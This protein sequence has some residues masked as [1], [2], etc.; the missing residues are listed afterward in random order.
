MGVSPEAGADVDHRPRHAP[1]HPVAQALPAASRHIALGRAVDEV[2]RAPRAAGHRVMTAIVPV[3]AAPPC[4]PPPRS[5]SSAVATAFSSISR[6]ARPGVREA[7]RTGRAACRGRRARSRGRRGRF[8]AVRR[9][10]RGPRHPSLSN[11]LG[12]DCARAAHAQVLRARRRAA[13]PARR[14]VEA[15]ARARPQARSASA[16]A[17]VAPTTR[18]LTR[19]PSLRGGVAGAVGTSRCGTDAWAA[20]GTGRIRTGRKRTR[21]LVRRRIVDLEPEAG[22]E[23]PLGREHARRRSLPQLA[24][25]TG[26]WA[27]RRR[28]HRQDVPGS[29]AST[30]VQPR[31]WIRLPRGAPRR[32]PPIDAAFTRRLGERAEDTK[33][34]TVT[35]GGV[36]TP[37]PLGHAEHVLHVLRVPG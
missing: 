8:G 7:S 29:L 11:A 34:C 13:T 28:E 15:R 37:R 10:L 25:A 3:A 14:E 30:S 20:R 1:V 26:R 21:R 6:T 22:I 23:Q 17:E 4:A 12:R 36:Y 24:A 31:T 18:I 19:A 5:T 32:S 2:A 33:G 9:G 27:V 16:I 35:R